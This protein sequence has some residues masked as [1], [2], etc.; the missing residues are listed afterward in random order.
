[1][2]LKQKIVVLTGAGVS[3]ES[4][5]KTFRDNDGLWENYSVDEVA[6]PDAWQ[7]NPALVLDFYNQRRQQLK[8]VEPNQAHFFIAELQNR[9][10]VHVVTQ[11]V[12][13]LHERAGSKNVLHLHGE[14]FKV[15]SSKQSDLVMDW[16]E[17]LKQGDLCPSGS[18]LRP[19]IVWFG[20][21]VPMI[22]EAARIVSEA[23][24]LIVIGTSLMVY[25]AAGLVNYV[26]EMV[27]IYVVDPNT[28]MMAH[29]LNVEF[30]KET[31]T[32]G[33]EVLRKKLLP[34]D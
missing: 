8:N 19:H 22:E 3:A 31:A 33:S 17:D 27:K 23:D 25:P 15:R 4:G 6:T 12:D 16:R 20:E 2:K 26:D 29:S 24:I 10:D 30:I 28:P 18:Q 32:K 14:L 34:D 13:D 5:I 9:Y 1:M 11:N 7:R 21:P